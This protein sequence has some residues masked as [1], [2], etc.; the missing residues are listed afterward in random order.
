[1]NYVLDYYNYWIVVFLMMAGFYTVI[2]ANNLVKKI[3]D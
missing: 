1:M 3:V 2:S